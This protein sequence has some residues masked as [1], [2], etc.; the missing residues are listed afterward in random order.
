MSR[1][2]F[3]DHQ[4]GTPV[5]ASVFEAMR[6]YFCDDFGNPASLHRSGLRA[7]EALALARSQ[8]A[9]FIHAESP[10]DILFT[11]SGTE[12][13]NLAVKGV[14]DA[15]RK[16]GNHIVVT[17]IEHP[18]VLKSSAFLE[19]NGFTCTRVPVNH[20]GW[21]DP[22]S[23]RAALTDRTILVCV[24]HVNHDIG[25]IEPVVNIGAILNERG[26]P[27]FV[28]A[29]ASGGWLAIDVRKIGAS[30]LSLAPH[31]FYG[32]K[33]VG[34][35]Y[36]NRRAR[37]ESQMH[38]GDQEKGWRAGTE[39]IPAIAGAGAACEEA[40]REL[41]VRIAHVCRLQ[42]RLWN[43][44]KNNVPCIRLNGPEVGPK[45]IGTN[46]SISVEFIEGEGLSLRCDVKGISVASG[47]S[48][49]SRSLK[50]PPVLSAI[51]LEASLAQGTVLFTLG[52]DNTQDDIDY[53]IDTFSKAVSYL[54]EMSP[55]WDEFKSGRIDSVISPRGS[56]ASEPAQPR[57]QEP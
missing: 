14:A 30:L 41:D 54:R 45:R 27:F 12:A 16:R 46:L 50:V 4:A 47:S 52:K 42:A 6:P 3:L 17:Q 18:S 49:V 24:H 33:G 1:F 19:K 15:N 29:T 28:D 35:L 53:T 20:E 26:I 5:S 37:I 32:P 56:A 51:G 22:E 55:L 9:S 38:G 43:G 48:C 8:A 21:V 11:S 39:N 25:T 36:K 10:D 13:A 44:L 2:V 57:Q 40:S 23:I 7:R 31:R 34:I